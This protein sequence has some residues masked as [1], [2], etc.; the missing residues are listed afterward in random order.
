LRALLLRY[1]LAFQAQVAQTAAC[2]G[3]HPVERRL[4][5]WL[6]MAHD[7]AEGDTFPMT[8]E[9]LSMMLGV[10]RA[11]VTVA[12]GALQRAGLIHY[13]R[14]GL[15]VTDRPGLEAAA[16]ECHDAVRREFQRLLGPAA[17]ARGTASGASASRAP[18]PYGNGQTAPAPSARRAL[19]EG[20]HRR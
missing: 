18:P 5:R 1:A 12:A 16:C 9:F 7:R 6:L 19:S 11:G 14:G 10:R 2:N 8:H 13:D 3:R 20:E 15:A 4:A 17:L